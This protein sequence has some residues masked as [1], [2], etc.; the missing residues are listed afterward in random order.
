VTP[1]FY[2]GGAGPYFDEVQRCADSGF[3]GFR[4]ARAEELEAAA[5]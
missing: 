1:L 3:P 4:F 5:G 2:F